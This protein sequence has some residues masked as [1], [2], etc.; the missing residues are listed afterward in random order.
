MYDSFVNSRDEFLT[1]YHKR[2]NIETTFASTGSRG[3]LAS[4]WSGFHNAT[5]RRAYWLAFEPGAR[6]EGPQGANFGASGSLAAIRRE[7][8]KCAS[9]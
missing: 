8:K 3:A 9:S 2:L 5:G 4:L 6:G 1:N 7:S